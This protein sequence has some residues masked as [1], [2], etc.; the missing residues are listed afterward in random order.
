MWHEE[1]LKMRVTTTRNPKFGLCCLNGKVQLPPLREPPTFLKNL[2]DPNGD[3]RGSQFK[4]NIRYYNCSLAFT[5][6]GGKIDRTVNNGRGPPVFKINGINHHLIGSLLPDQGQPPEFSQ[7]YIFDTQ[8]EVKNRIKAVKARDCIDPDILRGLIGMLDEYNPFCKMFRM[9]RDRFRESNNVNVK[10]RLIGTRSKDGRQYNVP[11][12]SEVAALIVPSDQDNPGNRDIILETHN[13]QFKRITELHPSYM[14]LQYP[15]MFPEGEDG[16]HTEILHRGATQSSKG[17]K[18]VSQREWFAYRFMFRWGQG[19]TLL[20]CGRLTQ[21]F[22]CDAYTS[23]W[24]ERARW[25]MKNQDKLRADIVQG[26]EDAVVRGDSTP[27][28]IGKRI[29]LPSS[30]TGSPRYMIQAYQD[31]MAIVRWAGPPDLFMTFTTNPKWPEITEALNLIPGQKAEDRPDLVSRVFKI[32]L[33]ELIHD[34][35]KG[36]H[37]GQ[38]KAG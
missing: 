37:F 24:A 25:V 2:L 23:V 12:A 4:Q 16:Y 13:R 35:T 8:N 15:L 7:M 38:A 17:R 34:I 36:C 26:L 1:R 21:Q 22:F 14:P 27:A 3:P 5:S 28:S 10:L 18:T 19:N 20:N 29:I 30:V 11:T 32:K 6:C 9:A 31:S 33:D